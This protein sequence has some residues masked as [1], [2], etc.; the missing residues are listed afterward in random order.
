L[1]D[2]ALF[3]RVQRQ[4]SA[5]F[6]EGARPVSFLPRGRNGIQTTGAQTSAKNLAWSHAAL[7]SA[8]AA[9]AD[10]MRAIGANGGVS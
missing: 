1:S 4:T 6:W 9:R 7:I 2:E 10:A 3:D 8:C 5:F